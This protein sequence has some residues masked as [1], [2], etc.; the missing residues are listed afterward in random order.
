MTDAGGVPRPA[1]D[2]R[3]L[4]GESATLT[5]CYEPAPGSVDPGNGTWPADLQL[6]VAVRSRFDDRQ[7]RRVAHYLTVVDQA[8]SVDPDAPPGTPYYL[9]DWDDSVAH[10]RTQPKPGPPNQGTPVL[11]PLLMGPL[12]PSDAS[13]DLPNHLGDIDYTDSSLSNWSTGVATSVPGVQLR[14]TS[15]TNTSLS[16]NT[17]A[18]HRQMPAPT[19]LMPNATLVIWSAPVNALTG[20]LPAGGQPVTLQIGL[21]RLHKN[22]N[23]I[24]WAATPVTHTYVHQAPGWEK[25]EIP[26]SLGSEQNFAADTYLRLR[27]TCS[28]TNAQ[29]CN[30]AYDNVNHISALYV[31]VK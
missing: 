12:A 9:F 29:D 31:Q 6:T 7:V 17:A 21:D 22:E 20:V 27:I 13:P 3:V 23:N 15:P 1:S 5:V 19:V 14:A 18:W 2:E 11:L 28:S 26:I 30:L 25:V 24:L 10:A 8:G 4:P 16:A